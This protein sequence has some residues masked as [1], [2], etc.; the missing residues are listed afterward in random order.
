MP[1][2]VAIPLIGIV[3]RGV[4]LISSPLW[5]CVGRT[6]PWENEG[7]PPTTDPETRNITEPILYKQ[8]EVATFVVEDS[9]GEYI[10]NGIRYQPVTVAYARENLVTTVLIKATIYDTD[11]DESVTFRQVGLY[12]KL[13]PT[14]GNESK[15]KLLPSEVS[16]PGYLEWYSNLEPI[17]VQPNQHQIFYIVLN[18]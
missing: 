9:N 16:D 10:V 8:C 18:F 7:N 14:Q 15:S 17:N 2:Y 3:S 5:I 6:T 11:L 4:D 12:S 1:N 13:I